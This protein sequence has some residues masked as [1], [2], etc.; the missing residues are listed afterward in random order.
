MRMVDI[1]GERFG[2][3]T[4]IRRADENYRSKSGA[5]LVQLV[6][7]CDCGKVATITGFNLQ[8]GKSKSCGYYY[9]EQNILVHTTHGSSP[10]RLYKIWMQMHSRCLNPNNNR[11]GGRGIS[12][13]DEWLNSFENFRDWVM[14]NGHDDALTIDRIDNDGNYEPTN[15]RWTTPKEQANNRGANKK[16]CK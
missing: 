10:S 9:N 7:K 2:M 6:C 14:D 11:Y 1:T 13:C 4:V 5:Q 12:I 8:S 3:L 16:V 15:C